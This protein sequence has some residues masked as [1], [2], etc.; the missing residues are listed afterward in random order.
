MSS[1]ITRLV[2]QKRNPNRVSVFVDDAF[3]CGLNKETVLLLG[4]RKGQSISP[5]RLL[6]ME[7][8]DALIDAKTYVGNLLTR[9]AYSSVEVRR[10]LGLKGYAEEVAEKTVQIFVD[11]GYLDDQQF[12]RQFARERATIKG[13]GTARIRMDLR[14][15]GIPSAFIDAALQ[16]ILDAE[17]ALERA[18]AI[19]QKRWMALQREPDPM[20]R[21]KRLFDFMLRRGYTMSAIQKIIEKLP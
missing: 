4:L 21:R 11:R 9:R 6:E 12:A 20:K 2:L 14:R 3:F 5:E 13:H 8:A 17:D 16:D 10:K 7:A 1:Q 19:A 18:E 15:K